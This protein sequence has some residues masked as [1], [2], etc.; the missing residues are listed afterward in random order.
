MWGVLGFLYWTHGIKRLQTTNLI[1]TL[2]RV[3]PRHTRAHAHTRTHT[4]YIQY[5]IR[6]GVCRQLLY[7]TAVR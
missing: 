1:N 3:P 7:R 4:N 2:I 5:I 6:L